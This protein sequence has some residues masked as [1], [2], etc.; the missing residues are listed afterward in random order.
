MS[1]STPAQGSGCAPAPVH[2]RRLRLN[3]AAL[4]DDSA[5]MFPLSSDSTVDFRTLVDSGSTDCFMDNDFASRFRLAR[6]TL[7]LPMRLHLFDGSDA[8]LITEYTSLPVRFPTGKKMTIPFLLTKLDPS[9]SAVLGHSWLRQNNPTI[10]WVRNSISFSPVDSESMLATDHNPY[11]GSSARARAVA[12]TARQ[13]VPAPAPAAPNPQITPEIRVI[14]AAPFAR[15]S[16]TSTVY[17]VRLQQTTPPPEAEGAARSASYNP[18]SET[19]E[20]IPPMYHDYL[21]VFSAEKAARLPEHRTYDIKVDLADGTPI[22]TGG[23]YPLSELENELLRKYIQEHLKMGHIRPSSSPGGAPVFFVK[24]PDGSG[25]RL[26]V[27]YRG[28]NN[29]LKKDKY[30]IPLIAGTLDRLRKAKLFTKLDLRSGYYNVRVAEGDEWKTAFRSRFGT[31]EYCVMPFG[32]ANAPAAFQRFMN[33]IFADL[34]DVYVVVYLDDILIFSEDPKD[35]PAH[36]R[37][38]LRRLREHD[39]Y[40]KPEKCEFH[41]TTIEYLGFVVTLDGIAMDIKKVDAILSWP[42][43]RKVKEVQSF[44]GF[45]NFYRRF[46]SGFSDIAAPLIRLTRK[47]VKW[48]FDLKCREAFAKLK[49]AFTTAPVL[50]HYDPALPAVVETDASDYALGAILSV[51]TPDGDLHPVAFHSRSFHGAELNYDTHDKELM[52]VHDAFSVWRHYL[53]FTQHVIDVV[54]DHKNLEYFTSTKMLS[55]RQARIS[56]YIASFKMTIRFRPGKLGAKPDALTRRADVYPKGGDSDYASAN[57]QNLRPLFSSAQLR[58]SIRATYAE[59]IFLRASELMD[60][61]TIRADIL[62]ALPTDP[63]AKEIRESLA[64]THPPPLWSIA[65]TGLIMHGD[66]VFVPDANSLRLR[67]LK[68]KHDHPTAGHPGKDK[69][70]KLVMRDFYWPKLRS[71][72]SDYVRSCVSCSRNKPRRHKPYGFLRPLPVA[73]RPWHSISMDFIEQLPASDGYTSILVIVDRLTKQAIFAPTTDKVNSEELAKLFLLNVFSKHGVPSH[74]S[75]DRGSEFI[76]HFSRSLGTALSMKLHF[77]SGHHP[78]ANGQAERTNQTLEQYLR[79]YCNYQQTDWASLLPLA[80]FAYN[81]APHDSTGVSPF[82]ANKGYNP[83]L[84]IHPERDLAS[85]R[86]KDLAVDL[87]QLHTA[88]KEQI[89]E[90]QEAFSVTANRRRKPPPDFQVGQ[91]VFISSQFL[92][93]TRPTRK[94]AERFLGPFDL[95]GKISDLS[96]VVK[97][98]PYLRTVHPVFHVSQ[99]EP[100]F[101][102]T[103]PD[104]EV[105]PPAPVEIDGELEF[106]VA[107]ILDSKLDRRYACRLRYYVRWA[108]YEGTSEEFEWLSAADLA[109]SAEII[110]SYHSR[111]PTRPGTFADF[112]KYVP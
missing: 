1:S 48:E 21:D 95:I 23:I 39:L 62:A 36:V 58:A 106:E 28:L 97:M 49:K 82:F 61:D 76:S 7:P 22:P 12:A 2:P 50:H 94:L 35:H 6:K 103:I 37:E 4:T 42:E 54:T 18:A 71:F 104:R 32:L 27:D 67:V 44:L 70:A 69:T 8:G 68:L 66:L 11:K 83:A 84:E 13:S 108:G 40:C 91:Q 30:P 55:R 52:A 53:E 20:N 3:A 15:L 19:G 87:D 98:P 79:F 60:I 86:A 17:I 101:P 51:I 59:S 73:E 46:I 74:V 26:C 9:C 38:V 75:S 90:A 41:A 29:L 107:E 63:E 33:H 5:L 92:N 25:L 43:P 56:A 45:A 112:R 77:T 99:L 34:L 110:E 24:K 80:E 88:L 10:D 14:G 96:F 64:S 109:H 31:F 89:R 72:V 85:L 111:N 93:T 47:T 81:N 100:A 16:K 57:P 105:P 65:E 78:E 102:N